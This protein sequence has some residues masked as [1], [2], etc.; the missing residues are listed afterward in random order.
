MQK[1]MVT[2]W[3]SFLMAGIAEGIFF[4]LVNPQ[5]MYFLG[6]V[7]EF[8]PMATY[9]IGF[10]AFWLLCASSSFLTCYLNRSADDINKHTHCAGSA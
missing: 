8:S 9:T 5:E 7:V 4:S 6:R 2:L 3:P 10:F 1:W